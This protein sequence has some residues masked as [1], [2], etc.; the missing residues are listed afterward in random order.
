MVVNVRESTDNDWR[1]FW[2]HIQQSLSPV[3]GGPEE[4]FGINS[5]PK[6]PSGKTKIERCQKLAGGAVLD[7]ECS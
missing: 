3:T 6:A 2:K 7:E 4:T 1:G 5:C